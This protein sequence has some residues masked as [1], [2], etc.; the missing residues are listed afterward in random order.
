MLP[1]SAARSMDRGNQSSARL[2][3]VIEDVRFVAHDVKVVTL[4]S[5]DYGDLP[6]HAAGSHV[7]LFLR[8]DL[9]RSY[10]LLPTDDLC[11]YEVA[12]KLSPGSRGGSQYIHENL[13]K[14]QIL[15]VGRPK[16]NFPL[17]DD[18][19]SAILIAGGIGITPIY[20]MART[21]AGSGR[22]WQLHYAFR[23]RKDAIFLSEFEPFGDRCQFYCD[24]SNGEPQLNLNRLL[25]EAAPDSHLYCCGPRGM[26][27]EFL[28][29]TKN[30]DEKYVHVE[31]F[32]GE[33]EADRTGGYHVE[34]L[35]TGKVIH[36]PPGIAL[37]DALLEAGADVAFSCK[38]GV[39]GSCETEVISGQPDHRDSFLTETERKANR[40]MMV[41]CSGSLS[42]KLV[43][44]L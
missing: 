42:D 22:T 27:D 29:L 4:A 26:I 24:E 12:V 32:Q 6:V 37:I 9:V 17:A 16:N 13:T 34:L 30:R 10:S 5:A 23:F 19:A 41:C 43:L 7:D 39:C 31:R 18:G 38:E 3:L 33:Q 28:A 40:L 15:E 44:N 25:R 14:G 2:E 35:K 36:V 20:A 11:R 8:E 1:A 21:L